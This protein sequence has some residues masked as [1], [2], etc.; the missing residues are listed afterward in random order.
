MEGLTPSPL[1][2][3][4]NIQDVT[5]KTVPG[6]AQQQGNY[7]IIK[8]TSPRNRLYV[9]TQSL[10]NISLSFTPVFFICQHVPLQLRPHSVPAASAVIS[11]VFVLA[12]PAPAPDRALDPSDIKPWVPHWHPF[13]NINKTTTAAPLVDSNTAAAPL[14]KRLGYGHSGCGCMFDSTVTS[15]HYRKQSG[16]YKFSIEWTTSS[17]VTMGAVFTNDLAKH[18]MTAMTLKYQG[19]GGNGGEYTHSIDLWIGSY[20]GKGLNAMLNAVSNASE[21]QTGPKGDGSPC[22]D[23]DAP[24]PS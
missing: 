12:A 13:V 1:E 18:G 22:V 20:F 21:D 10:L 8:L 23:D 4:G 6:G 11:H 3:P 14:E 24:P 9:L 2:I 7:P 15:C 17:T 5:L 19:G 16:G